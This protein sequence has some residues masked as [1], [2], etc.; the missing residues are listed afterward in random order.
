[1][2]NNGSSCASSKQGAPASAAQ[3]PAGFQPRQPAEE[4]RAALWAQRRLTMAKMLHER[5]GD[6]AI[7]LEGEIIE[8]IIQ[9]IPQAGMTLSVGA[10]GSCECATIADALAA[11]QPAST[12][13]IPQR[14]LISREISDGLV[15]L[16]GDTIALNPGTY[17][18]PLVLQPSPSSLS[19]RGT[20]SAPADV[21]VE[22][23]DD[24][25][26]AAG[27]TEVQ[28]AYDVIRRNN[29]TRG[30]PQDGINDALMPVL[31]AARTLAAA[32]IEAGA[33]ALPEGVRLNAALRTFLQ[34]PTLVGTEAKRR[35]WQRLQAPLRVHSS[36]STIS[37]LTLRASGSSPAVYAE[38]GGLRMERVVCEGQ[39]RLETHSLLTHCTVSG[40]PY[41]AGVVVHAPSCTVSLHKC[42][43]RDCL[44][45]LMDDHRS[46][47]FFN[48]PAGDINLTDVEIARCEGAAIESERFSQ[49]TEQREEPDAWG[50]VGRNGTFSGGRFVGCGTLQRSL[51]G[52]WSG[53]GA[54]VVTA[55][56]EDEC[57]D[58]GDHDTDLYESSEGGTPPSLVPI[59]LQLEHAELGEL[60]YN[61]AAPAVATPPP[62]LARQT[63]A[64]CTAAEQALT[65]A[66]REAAEADRSE[67]ELRRVDGHI[68]AERFGSHVQNK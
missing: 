26:A 28:E 37:N 2:G 41:A 27:V 42:S 13:S 40:V 31:R 68:A 25:A 22:W 51:P 30:A 44:V 45:G 57:L 5:L 59:L 48:Q 65:E 14:I 50:Y 12:R 11:A 36:G 35:R 38:S 64:N 23:G 15:M 32:R 49:Q 21:V 3:Q 18:E 19:I 66:A 55:G 7:W 56:T 6:E 53:G 20:G 10:E 24:L 16:Q 9:L 63:S 47:Q 62:S 60:I 58:S 33:T 34:Q 17:R 43:V 8:L 29:T 52:A 46:G 39:A 61:A 4:R 1:M 67:R 54:P